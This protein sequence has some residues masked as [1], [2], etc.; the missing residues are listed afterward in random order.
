M[1]DSRRRPSDRD[2]RRSDAPASVG[3]NYPI[4]HEI[5]RDATP[6]RAASA[7]QIASI[8]KLG[9]NPRLVRY[10][11]NCTPDM[12][13]VGRIEHTERSI[14]INEI[15]LSKMDARRIGSRM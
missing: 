7:A 1:W 3:D 11:A 6:A 9:R 10:H 2:K 4:F 5:D 14:S 13:F 8:H 12:G 15:K